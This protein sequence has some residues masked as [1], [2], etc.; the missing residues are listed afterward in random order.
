LAPWSTHF[1][2]KESSACFRVKLDIIGIP[3]HAWF[4]STAASIL[5]RSCSIH[6]VDRDTTSKRDMRRFSLEGWAVDPD[7]IPREVTISITEPHYN[8][9]DKALILNPEDM[10]NS[11]QKMLDYTI[12]IEIM[13]V[14]HMA[15]STATQSWADG[16]ETSDEGSFI[17]IAEFKQ[18]PSQ[19]NCVFCSDD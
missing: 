5:G 7:E 4:R 13:E 16:Y 18:K 9:E 17:S 14:E 3:E 2:A 8:L 10:M 1:G 19:G 12:A 6:R 15:P 11:E